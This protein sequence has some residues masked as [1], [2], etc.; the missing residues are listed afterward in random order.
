MH[1]T[2]RNH[3]VNCH[4][5]ADD[6]QAYVSVPVSDV[7]S[8][9]TALQHCNSDISSWCSPRHLQLNA[10]KTELIWFGSR[11]RLQ[12]LS[13]HDL[14]LEVGILVIQAVKCVRD[15]GVH[16]DSELTMETH[17]SKVVSACFY[18]LRNI[19]QVRRVVGQDI[20]Q[21][22]V[23]AFVLSRLD[24]CKSLLSG[25]PRST[26][27]PLRRVMNAAARVVTALSTRDHVKPALKQLHW[28]PVE[29]RIS[30]NSLFDWKPMEL[31]VCRFDMVT[32]WQ[33]RDYTYKLCLLM[34]YIHTGQAPQYL[35]NC[36]STI[37][38]SGNRY[39]LR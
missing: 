37:S 10:T 34:H 31:L 29:Q 27:Q 35:S 17:I 36:V 26:I 9:R 30:Y 23:S 33:G 18:Q 5:F 8:A 13:D 39:R 1:C 32:S 22:L 20:T 4:L 7:S 28:L 24:Y 19:R 16:L 12:R 3:Q 38:S 6:Q 11:Q 21:Q 14:T 2:E 15:L 25:L